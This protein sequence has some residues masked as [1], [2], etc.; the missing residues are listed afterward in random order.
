MGVN[1]ADA[2]IRASETWVEN[3]CFR[4][5]NGWFETKVKFSSK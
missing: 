3:L 2:S 1:V 5:L 4:G